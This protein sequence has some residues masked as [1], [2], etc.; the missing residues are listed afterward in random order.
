MA[1]RVV[2]LM[3]GTSA[4]G[5]DAA[6]CV[7]EGAPP[8]LSVRIERARLFP[9]PPDLRARILH[10]CTPGAIGTDALCRL[11]AEIGAAFAE[12]AAALIDGETVDLIASHGQTVWHNVLPDG[13]VSATLQIGEAALIAERTGITVISNFRARDVAAG[14]Q[15]APLVA[16]VDH[17]LLRHPHA[18]RAVQ[19]IGGI[20]NVTL[21]P[22]L[23]M[24]DAA[25][26][27]FDTGPGNALI[28]AAM[29]ALTGQ[30][31]DAGGAFAAAGQVN[32]AWLT[33]LLGHPY[34]TRPLP[35]TTGRE[36][37]GA[38]MAGDLV[39]D[40]SARGLDA[41]SIIATLTALTAHSIAEA[42]A[43]YAPAPIAEVIIGGGG[44]HNHTLMAHLRAL[45][46]GAVLLTG[47]QVGQPADFK[48]ALAFAVLGYETWHNRPGALPAQTGARRASVLGQ[49]TPGDNYAALLHRTWLR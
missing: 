2:G 43:R 3:S 10:A 13:R 44:A 16:Y 24:P 12:A 25:L 21:L 30:P 48:E 42:Y 31:F 33:H 23:N 29:F 46:D 6:L 47:D 49:I 32:S 17:L 8:H 27:A 1:L 9:H 26:I 4:D 11:N 19:N 34:F 5:I 14:G 7:I 35:K 22:P 18:W 39:R 20:G 37:F 40:G 15:G 36:L 28:D 41:P 45:L 38:A